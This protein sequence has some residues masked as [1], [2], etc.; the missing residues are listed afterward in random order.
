MS[1][2]SGNAKVSWDMAG[3]TAAPCRQ[4]VKQDA[5]GPDLQCVVLLRAEL[6][7]GQDVGLAAT[8]EVQGVQHGNITW[9]V[10]PVE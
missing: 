9:R 3:G 7:Y 6:R 4:S 2:A 8:V 10:N 5:E 1:S